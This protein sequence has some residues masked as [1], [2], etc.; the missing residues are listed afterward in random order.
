MSTMLFSP[1]FHYSIMC[2][3]CVHF[4][5]VFGV[6]VYVYVL[7]SVL[8]A[9]LPE[10]NYMILQL[11]KKMTKC[12]FVQ[13]LQRHCD[14]SELV[15]FVKLSSVGRGRFVFVSLIFWWADWT[16][17]VIR[18]HQSV[19]L[20][21]CPSVC[22]SVTVNQDVR[23]KSIICRV[24]HT[25]SERWKRQGSSYNK[26]LSSQYYYILLTMS[27]EC[28]AI[29][30]YRRSQTRLCALLSQQVNYTNLYCPR[31]C[32]RLNTI[33]WACDTVWH[34]REHNVPISNP[35]LKPSAS[36]Q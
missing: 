24:V 20:Y 18:A 30:S 9:Q 26:S 2:V 10:L 28:P 34:S 19:G 8:W 17:N 11:F 16:D 27:V 7:F 14:A 3:C 36:T 33:W 4:R 29:K 5:C 6:F 1:S 13:D 22:L 15:S 32:G 35:T 23:K 12:V 31:I 25:K 21:V